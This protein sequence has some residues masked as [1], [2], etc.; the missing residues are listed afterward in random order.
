MI[1]GYCTQRA[2]RCCLL[3]EHAEQRYQHRRDQRCVE[4]F[5]V[6]QDA[7]VKQ[8]FERHDGLFGH[9]DIDLVDVAA[10]NGLSQAVKKIA[11]AQG[12][13]QECRAFLIDQM[14]QCQSLDQ[15][16]DGKHDDAR[17]DKSSQIGG[18]GIGHSGPEWNPFGKARHRQGCKKHHRALRKV[19][20]A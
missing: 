17:D 15:P 6:N 11:D 1:V 13:H 12:G 20:Y 19:E 14:A 18:N 2:P 5:L 16:G 7:A 9:A 3:E 4:V 8:C 10:E